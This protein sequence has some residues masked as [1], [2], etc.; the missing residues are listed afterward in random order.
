MKFKKCSSGNY[1]LIDPTLN[2]SMM[3]ININC[4]T[5]SFYLIVLTF[6]NINF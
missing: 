3:T 4:F 6:I 1:F 5:F 2:V